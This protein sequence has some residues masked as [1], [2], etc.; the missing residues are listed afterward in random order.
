[1]P[2]LKTSVDARV[3]YLHWHEMIPNTVKKIEKSVHV[4]LWHWYSWGSLSAKCGG[5][6]ICCKNQITVCCSGPDSLWWGR[7]DQGSSPENHSLL[8]GCLPIRH[9]SG[10]LQAERSGCTPRYSPPSVC[11]ATP[12]PPPPTVTRSTWRE[13]ARVA[14]RRRTRR[15]GGCTSRTL[16][17]ASPRG[18]S[19]APT[20]PAAAAP[21]HPSGEEFFIVTQKDKIDAHLHVPQP[22]PPEGS[23]GHKEQPELTSFLTSLC[24]CSMLS[25]FLLRQRRAAARFLLRLRMSWTNSS[26]SLLSLLCFRSCWKALRLSAEMCSTENGSCICGMHGVGFIFGKQSP[27][28][29]CLFKKIIIITMM[30]MGLWSGWA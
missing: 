11:S 9:F 3:A 4:T 27:K 30:C 24:S 29:R 20:A 2:S 5:K 21:S 23:R 28:V 26:C 17:D 19:S 10:S 15:W 25:T 6:H 22:P 18:S 13:S 7:R 8:L 12:P 16:S 1:M 14:P